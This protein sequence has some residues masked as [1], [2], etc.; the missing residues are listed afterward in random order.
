MLDIT[1]TLLGKHKMFQFIIICIC[2][3]NKVP[4]LA[5]CTSIPFNLSLDETFWFSMFCMHPDILF[6]PATL[7]ICMQRLDC[8]TL[9]MHATAFSYCIKR[10]C[11]LLL[12]TCSFYSRI[13]SFGSDPSIQGLFLFTILCFNGVLLQ[14]TKIIQFY[15]SMMSIWLPPLGNREYSYNE[16]L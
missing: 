2:G 15:M 6:I 12:W 4:V 16:I 3:C 7:L 10:M 5:T 11:L 14:S 1:L 9:L 8:A 13:I